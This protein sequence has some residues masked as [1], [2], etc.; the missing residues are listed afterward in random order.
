MTILSGVPS[1]L[2]TMALRCVVCEFPVG[3]VLRILFLEREREERL[4]EAEGD[5]KERAE[6]EAAGESVRGRGDEI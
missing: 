3:V 2:H 5:E 4:T 1:V 6:A